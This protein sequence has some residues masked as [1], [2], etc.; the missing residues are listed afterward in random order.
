MIE[1]SVGPM[2][3]LLAVVCLGL[4]GAALETRAEASPD[5]SRPPHG[6]ANAPDSLDALLDRFLAALE[7]KDTA[8]LNQL[9]VSRDEYLDVIVPGTVEKGKPPRQ[10]SEAPK[11]YFWET[12]DFKSGEFAKLMVLRF[13][14]RHYVDR[15]VEFTK[16]P[17]EYAWYT[18][19]GKLKMRLQGED[20]AVYE[21]KTGWVAE[22]DGKYKFIGFELGE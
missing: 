4:S 20:Q 11:K 15:Q 18:A 16:P 17:R 21:L 10:V 7:K 22:V 1:R 19:K 14:G 9:R 6:L 2:F 5:A 12:L 3:V 13:G 8:A